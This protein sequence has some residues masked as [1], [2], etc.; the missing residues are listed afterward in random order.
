MKRNSHLD[1]RRT[2]TF[3]ELGRAGFYFVDT[4]TVKLHVPNPNWSVVSNNHT[5][6]YVNED[7]P[8]RFSVVKKI[9]PRRPIR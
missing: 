1:P 6:Y 8:D 5:M 9:N 3:E 2:Y 7:S 4:S